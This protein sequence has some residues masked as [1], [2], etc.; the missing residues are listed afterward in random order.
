MY[1]QNSPIMCLL[2]NKEAINFGTYLNPFMD[3][4]AP[5]VSIST[6]ISRYPTEFVTPIIMLHPFLLLKEL[7]FDAYIIE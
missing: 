1:I 7:L 4:K 6:A 3:R 5:T 2:S